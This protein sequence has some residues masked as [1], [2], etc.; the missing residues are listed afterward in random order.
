MGG[1]VFLA[2]GASNLMMGTGLVIDGVGPQTSDR[3]SA[4]RDLLRRA[5]EGDRAGFALS[6]PARG[7]P[8][9]SGQVVTP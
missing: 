2:S 8:A 9:E 3:Q 6:R 5:L 4:R 7:L 1:V